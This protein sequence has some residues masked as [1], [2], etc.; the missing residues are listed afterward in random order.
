MPISSTRVK[1]LDKENKILV[2][3]LKDI[4]SNDIL[5]DILTPL[6]ELDWLNQFDQLQS[7]LDLQQEI[8]D[9]Y[10][11]IRDGGIVQFLG[12]NFINSLNLTNPAIAHLAPAIALIKE[13]DDDSLNAFMSG[14]M[15]SAADKLFDN[16]SI[17]QNYKGITQDIKSQILLSA[18]EVFGSRVSQGLVTVDSLINGLG[19]GAADLLNGAA[20]DVLGTSGVTASLRSTASGKKNLSG[21]TLTNLL[22]A[23][24]FSKTSFDPDKP[25]K[26]DYKI[27]DDFYGRGGLG[28]DGSGGNWSGSGGG[29][30]PGGG[31]TPTDTGIDE[32]QSL[33]L[34]SLMMSIRRELCRRFAYDITH[35]PNLNRNYG[36]GEITY[37]DLVLGHVNTSFTGTTQTMAH[38]GDGLFTMFNELFEKIVFVPTDP[39]TG[40]QRESMDA[41]KAGIDAMLRQTYIDELEKDENELYKF[42]DLPV[43]LVADYVAKIDESQDASGI[44]FHKPSGEFLEVLNDVR[45]HTE[46]VVDKMVVIYLKNKYNSLDADNVAIPVLYARIKVA[47][48]I[49]ATLPQ[50]TSP[51]LSYKLRAR[52]CMEVITSIFAEKVRDS[53]VPLKFKKGQAVIEYSYQPKLA[54]YIVN[55]FA[56]LDSHLYNFLRSKNMSAYSLPTKIL[57]ACLFNQGKVLQVSDYEEGYLADHN[58]IEKLN[59]AFWQPEVYVRGYDFS[60]SFKSPNLNTHE[61]TSMTQPLSKYKFAGGK[62]KIV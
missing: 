20:D 36:V 51:P 55:F 48:K 37:Q 12:T 50:K 52:I 42:A 44:N 9:I 38:F 45:A 32:S 49:M 11:M 30:G 4:D 53:L 47:Q 1:F 33:V 17:F 21:D 29:T 25:V 15:S 39:Y 56:A 2:K 61:Y 57:H 18:L 40:S 59:K 5:S 34:L 58:L 26:W 14:L 3:N 31:G 10:N 43:P 13:L 23:L 28:A 46:E 27:P 6:T 41:Y 24:S 60:Y 16:P 19:D 7:L 22:K 8:Q 62:V 54:E 35:D